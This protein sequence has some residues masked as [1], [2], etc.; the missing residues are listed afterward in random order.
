M[1]AIDGKPFFLEFKIKG[2]LQTHTGM[3][4]RQF[5]RYRFFMDVLGVDCFL[6]MCERKSGALYYAYMSSLPVRGDGDVLFLQGGKIILW[7]T[8]K[9]FKL[10]EGCL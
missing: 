8:D 1:F 7:R 3:D 5:C 2:S 6:V 4:Y 9:F 10:F